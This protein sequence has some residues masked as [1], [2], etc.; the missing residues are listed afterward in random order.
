MKKRL[1]VLIL[2]G[3]LLLL[4]GGY[5]A[6]FRILDINRRAE[7]YLS[8]YLAQS[9][10]VHVSRLSVSVLPWAV[11]VRD[12]EL[13]MKHMPL[14]MKIKRMR[15]GFNVYTIITKRL[16]SISNLHLFVSNPVFIWDLGDKT[17]GFDTFSLTRNPKI[18][19]TGIPSIHLNI[20]GGSFVFQRGDSTLVFADNINGWF[21]GMTGSS[22][23]ITIE[24]NVLSP[25]VNTALKG[26]IDRERND[27]TL[28]LVTKGCDIST[29]GTCVL[30]G[31]I[32]PVSGLLDIDMTLRK[33]GDSLNLRGEYTLDNGSFV[34]NESRLG[35]SDVKARGHLNEHEAYIDTAYVTVLGVTP[36]LHGLVRLKPAPELDIVLDADSIDLARA[37][38]AYFPGNDQ[39]LH[40][41]ADV[42]ASVNGPL[43]SLTTVL[44]ALS[45]SL[46]YRDEVLRNLTFRASLTR[47]RIILD[48]LKAVWRG[49]RLNGKGTSEKTADSRVRRV[50]AHLT[51]Q[52]K[53]ALMKNFGLDVS[54]R[55]NIEKKQ[56]TSDFS[57][58]L[59][60]MGETVRGRVSLTG[61]RTDF[62]VGNDAFSWAG[63]VNHLTTDASLTSTLACVEF[64][65]AR[66][67]GDDYTGLIVDGEG[68][69]AGN[70]ERIDLAGS[71]RLRVGNN[72]N[73]VL[74]GKA[75]V[76]NILSRGRVF[77]M[78][79]RLVDLHLMYSHPMLWNMTARSDSVGTGVE[80]FD[81]DGAFLSAKLSHEGRL[82]GYLDL[83]GFPLE[84]II[85][86][87]KREEFSHQGTITG[88]AVLGG[89]LREPVF[90]TPDT[91]RVADLRIGGLDRLSGTALVSGSK[92]ELAFTDIKL[93]RDDIHV[94][95]AD[96]RWE[97][98]KPFI[99]KAAGERIDMSAI[100][101][102]LS[103]T[104]KT[105]GYGD[106]L[107][108]AEFTRQSGTVSGSA[109]V[110]D[111][112]FL[113]VPFD[114]V[115]AILGGGSDG[116]ILSD[117]RF[118]KAGVYEGEGNA[119]SGYFWRDRTESSGLH[120]KLTLT[121]DLMRALPYLSGSIKKASGN[122][123]LDLVLGGS[124]Q[125]PLVLDV[126]LGVDNGSLTPAFLFGEIKNIHA[127]LDVDDGVMTRSG[128]KAVRIRQGTG[129]YDGKLLTVSNYHEGDKTWETLEKPGLISIVHEDINL[130][131]GV[132]NIALDHGKKRDTTLKLHVPGFMEEKQTGLFEIT[133][134]NG[135]GFILGASELDGDHLTPYVSG[136]I[137]LRSGDIHFP[138]LTAE[139]ENDEAG[140]SNR[141]DFLEDMFWD[142]D[143]EI[144]SNVNY[145][146]EYNF[147]LGRFAGT[148]LWRNE[149]K[150][151]ENSRFSVYGRISDG[152]FRVTGTTQSSNG[153]VTY[154]GY[155]FTIEWAEL[156]LDTVNV[157]RPAILTGR[158]RTVV[159]DD[160]TG[161]S[162]DI[163]LHVNFIDRESGRRQQARS[164]TELRDD[165][166]DETSGPLTRFDAGPLGIIE[167]R[168]T[169]NN[170]ADDTQEKIL[171]HLGISLNT[172]GEAATRAFAA[173]MDNYYF[174]PLLRP[175]EERI[176]KMLKIDMFKISPAFF[177]SFAQSQFGYNPMHDPS[178]DYMLFD[179]S[180]VILGEFLL[181]DWFVSYTGQ[182]GVGRDFLYRREKGF[183]HDVGLQYII[184]RNLRFQLHYNYDD[185][186]RQDDTRFEI[187][188]DF[189]FK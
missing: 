66:F 187:R 79:G 88:R 59:P 110:R 14:V 126:D 62:T 56:V 61:D 67:L 186:I 74:T 30:S 7:Y 4:I 24:G 45:D 135:H 37:Y 48:E 121:G 159:V 149:I 138:L 102:I 86:I 82:G 58:R 153:V 60:D 179:K 171:A 42:S 155:N 152:S 103:S 148:T 107:L 2:F 161:V 49:Y 8:E 105:D 123:R 22:V 55:V 27:V 35:I 141:A 32:T 144:G 78:E 50:K 180:K 167:L 83:H 89:T 189:R 87:F 81:D 151:D 6:L 143:I 31:D 18:T 90:S 21:D 176:K 154:Y 93:N 162:T 132:L 100:A 73:T 9:F 114:S 11:S 3:L 178:T 92:Y 170:P 147:N 99:L 20:S 75:A 182:Y 133:G 97:S 33:T 43:Q 46:R 25:S 84:R 101:D 120:M 15:V 29:G 36:R 124:W 96:G 184:Q 76:E 94:M 72:L 140:D 117:M 166:F 28:H 12:A 174:N 185:I 47:D 39:V 177:G 52:N 108:T 54:G 146:N 130:D 40:G 98:G 142:L 172:I 57:L 134:K 131:F 95:E 145:V 41:Y 128:L 116:F 160:S 164:G 68:A 125:D 65:V 91:V 51:G 156:A 64:P 183:Y 122:C 115:S 150:I 106:Y 17:G 10:D 165:D 19:M 175:F 63:T 169:S 127:V 23:E 168:F 44:D 188:Y 163:F 69:L 77:T 158:A 137:L 112:H 85:D 1:W 139:I 129:L 70:R 136:N 157:A 26:V 80:I 53:L 111:G 113:D 104:R 34:L 118:S 181:K 71:Y 119:S 13:R 173:G 38:S 16:H 109:R 5:M